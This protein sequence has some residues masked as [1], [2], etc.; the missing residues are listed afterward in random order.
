MTCDHRAER[1]RE[2]EEPAG[3]TCTEGPR[4]GG[5]GGEPQVPRTRLPLS[6]AAAAGPQ[7][8]RQRRGRR[9]S[10]RTEGGWEARRKE[11]G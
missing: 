1:A 7:L 11:G 8:R 6:F 2:R 9:A 3:E 10:A 5:L 4:P